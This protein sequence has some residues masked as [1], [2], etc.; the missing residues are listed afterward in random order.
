MQD[1]KAG[2]IIGSSPRHMTYAQLIAVPIGAL[3]VS[4]MYPVL[5]GAYGIGGEHGLTSPISAKWAGFAEFLAAG[6]KA[7]PP[8]ATAALIVASI[9]GVVLT[10]SEQYTKKVPSPT[11]MGIGMLVP[12]AAIA[13]MFLGGLFDLVWRRGNPKQANA[14]SIPLASGLIAGEA[15]LAV[16]LAIMSALGATPGK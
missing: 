8:G 4:Y 1:F 13:T 12:G 14:Y 10:I 11:S 16:I 2:H 15:I 3:A 6:F 9:L 5:R 7:L